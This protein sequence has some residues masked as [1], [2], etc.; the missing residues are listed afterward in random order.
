MSKIFVVDRV[1]KADKKVFKVDR[2]HKAKFH[3]FEVD[4]AHKAKKDHLWFYCYY[5]RVCKF[6]LLNLFHH[7]IPIPKVH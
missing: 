1:N 6:V 7:H 5:L 3:F 4:R 2:S